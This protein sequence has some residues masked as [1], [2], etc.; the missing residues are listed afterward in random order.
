[1]VEAARLYHA[2]RRRGGVVA[3]RAQ[4]A[5]RIGASAYL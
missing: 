1:M 4:Q 2:A 5:G 3:A